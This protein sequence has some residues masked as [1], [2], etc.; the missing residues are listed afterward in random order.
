MNE[1]E[2]VIKERTST[3][4]YDKTK[5]LSEAEI[6]ELISYAVEAPSSFDIQHWRF[7][8]ITKPEDKTRLKAV[9]Y[10]QQ[11][12]EDAAVTFIVLGDLRGYEKT[13]LI[14]DRAVENGL[15]PKEVRDYIVNAAQSYAENEQMSRDEAIRSGSLAAMTLMLAAKSRG[16][17]SG[18][19]VGF[20]PDA[21]KRE[22]GISDRYLPV[23]LVTV[24]YAA[25]G[26]HARMYR[27][28][29][30]DVLAFDRGREF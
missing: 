5:T 8:A 1:V 7:V 10:N 6:K 17:S 15:A 2:K 11:Q 23:M 30:D 16:L 18:P 14:W 12:V 3:K 22:F 24:G 4:K 21:L 20:E 19:M 28:P 13:G 29:V 25:P 9:S 26:N 27:L